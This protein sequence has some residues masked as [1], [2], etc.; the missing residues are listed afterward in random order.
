M[1]WRQRGRQQAA[2]ALVLLVVT[3]GVVAAAEHYWRK[4]LALISVG[5]LLGAG[6]R[7]V[8]P[9]RAAG[10]L[11]VRSRGFDVVVLG[12]LGVTIGV[13]AVVIPPVLT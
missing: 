8:L 9:T 11:V 7:L 5:L 2:S 3:V 1:T 12:G 6:L 13:L 4:G 10:G